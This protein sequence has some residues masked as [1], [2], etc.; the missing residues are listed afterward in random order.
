MWWDARGKQGRYEQVDAKLEM[1]QLSFV[2]KVTSSSQILTVSNQSRDAGFVVSVLCE[3][4]IT[5]YMLKV[6]TS[7]FLDSVVF[8][9]AVPSC[10]FNKTM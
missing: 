4:G 10:F 3:A 5:I 1:F 2:V 9:N 7:M 8:L 6:S